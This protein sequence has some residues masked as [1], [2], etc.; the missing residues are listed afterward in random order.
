MFIWITNRHEQFETTLHIATD[1][2]Y[3]DRTVIVGAP[4]VELP[5][6]EVT[7]KQSSS[8]EFIQFVE[9]A[10]KAGIHICFCD[11]A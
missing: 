6:G 4:S 3:F 8:L 1:K 9:A 11:K 10:R 5:I 2:P 7:P